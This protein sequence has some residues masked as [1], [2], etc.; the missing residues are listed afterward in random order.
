[1]KV[2]TRLNFKIVLIANVISIILFIVQPWLIE[3]FFVFSV[4]FCF[5]AISCFLL[6]LF[7]SDTSRMF[8]FI[9]NG[10]TLLIATLYM[11]L[12]TINFISPSYDVRMFGFI[13]SPILYLLLVVNCFSNLS[14]LFG[15]YR[16]RQK[17]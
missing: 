8:L 3:S 12:I 5:V 7:F 4:I 14:V 2:V 11:I 17:T 6:V 15:F 1:M 9:T 16:A 10:C 13:L